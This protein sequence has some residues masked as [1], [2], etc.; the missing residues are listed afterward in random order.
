M[1]VFL[2]QIW[3]YDDLEK[4]VGIFTSFDAAQTAM[5]IHNPRLT[6]KSHGRLSHEEEIWHFVFGASS[7]DIWQVPLSGGES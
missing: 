2:V 4:T 5:L 7:A 3:N 1:N 6:L